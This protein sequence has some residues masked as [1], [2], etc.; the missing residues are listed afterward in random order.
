[1][2]HA[3]VPRVRSALFVPAQRED[4]LAKA[5][6]RGADA[7]IIDLEDSVPHSQKNA[8]RATSGSWIAGRA[9]PTGPVITVRVNALEEG[10]LRDDLAAVVHPQL[11]AI[12]VPK[13]DSAAQVRHVA[14]AIAYEEGRKGMEPGTVRIWPLVETAHAVRDAFDIATAS[15]RVAFMGGGTGRDGDL[16]RALNYRWSVDGPETHYIRSKVLVDVRA[17]GVPNPISGLV[18]I[19]DDLDAVR[20]YAEQARSLGY[21]GVQVIHPSHVAVANAVFTPTTEEL[22]EAQAV[23]DALKSGEAEGKGAIMHGGRMID[24]PNGDA[25]LRLIEEARRI[26][27]SEN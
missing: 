24:I 3:P 25:A 19:V 2:S 27:A 17:A 11:T 22:S 20:R 23:L 12:V 1:M 16:A 4:F 14:E 6:Q 21:E 5:D 7:V 9:K 10:C 18:A 13:I 8:G 26:A 15:D